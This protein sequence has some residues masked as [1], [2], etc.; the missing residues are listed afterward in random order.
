MTT[1]RRRSR[2]TRHHPALLAAGLLALLVLLLAHVLGWLVLTAAIA[3]GA[4]AL[5]QHRRGQA[6]P[7]T[8][9]VPDASPRLAEAEAERDQLHGQLARVTAE[10]D[11]LGA[12]AAGLWRRLAEAT[13]AAHAAWDAA[14]SITP[15]PAV[16]PP[17]AGGQ[18]A[19]LLADPRS[20]ARPL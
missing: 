10:R 13:D 6:P 4:Y 2:R 1:T 18:R 16:A 15:R 5:G 17:D 7:R 20:G 9:I 11:Q 3:A 8:V 19:A 12:E 14:A